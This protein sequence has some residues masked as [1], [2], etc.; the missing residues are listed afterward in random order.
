MISTIWGI[1]GFSLHRYLLPPETKANRQRIQGRFFFQSRVQTH[2]HTHTHIQAKKKREKGHR[3]TGRRD[4]PTDRQGPFPL[5]PPFKPWI[6]C[7]VTLTKPHSFPALSNGS[8]PS[9]LAGFLGILLHQYLDLLIDFLWRLAGS[10]SGWGFGI[11]VLVALV[12]WMLAIPVG[13][14]AAHHLPSNQST[15][16]RRG[17][18]WDMK[19]SG[20]GLTQDLTPPIKPRL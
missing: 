5:H 13:L 11:T 18:L 20:K 6:F 17:I 1:F 9:L 19:W 16:A 12:A 14:A 8:S 7:L 10:A 15:L 4:R 2:T 3:Q